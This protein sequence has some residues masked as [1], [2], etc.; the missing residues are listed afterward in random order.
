MIADTCLFWAFDSIEFAI[1]QS[2]L[3]GLL[4]FISCIT[5]AAFGLNR[6][7]PEPTISTALVVLNPPLA[8]SRPSLVPRPSSL[9]HSPLWPTAAMPVQY[10]V[11]FAE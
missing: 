7:P 3:S 9:N 4:P 11:V 8:H 2:A 1:G 6:S 10:N 5:L